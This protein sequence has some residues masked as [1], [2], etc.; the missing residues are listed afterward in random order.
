[1]QGS[2]LHGD[3]QACTVARRYAAGVTTGNEGPPPWAGAP[4]YTPHRELTPHAPMP[5][6]PPYPANIDHPPPPVNEPAARTGFLP[7]L[8]AAVVWALVDL[9]LVLVVL[10][11]PTGATA[12]RLA[13]GL[14]LTALVTA[15][16]VWAFARRRA[17]SFG[18]LLLATAP[19]FWILRAVMTPLVG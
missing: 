7:T 8:G 12:L 14:V 15:A 18:L 2:R 19:V 9:V 10:G 4:G 5:G 3:H 17:W 11:L 6:A 16:G 13:A 1:M